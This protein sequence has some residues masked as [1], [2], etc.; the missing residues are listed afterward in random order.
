M[1]YLQKV[2]AKMDISQFMKESISDSRSIKK[3][4]GQKISEASLFNQHRLITEPQT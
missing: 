2:L 3:Q 1:T 4:F